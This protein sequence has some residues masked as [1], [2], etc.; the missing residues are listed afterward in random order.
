MEMKAKINRVDDDCIS[1]TV[2]LRQA[3]GK[4]KG[5][6]LFLETSEA[7]RLLFDLETELF[8]VGGGQ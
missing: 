1:L 4:G 8:P 6:T 2:D 7:K 3:H 5:A